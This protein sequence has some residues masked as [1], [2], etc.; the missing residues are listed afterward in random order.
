[1][2]TYHIRVTSAFKKELKRAKKRDK[3]LDKLFHIVDLLAIGQELSPRARDH[4]PTGNFSGTKECH[5]EP[6]WLLIYE[7]DDGILACC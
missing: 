1:M 3:N 7:K 4:A 5:I 6:D 2:T